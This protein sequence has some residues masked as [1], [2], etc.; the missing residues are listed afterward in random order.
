MKRPTDQATP[1][2]ASRELAE[3]PLTV[4]AQE[5]LAALEGYAASL[6]APLGEVN[7]PP[8]A[9]AAS[10]D[11]RHSD[12]I[13]SLRAFLLGANACLADPS[14]GQT[15][16]HPRTVGVEL[17]RAGQSLAAATHHAH[18]SGREALER[19]V[20]LLGRMPEQQRNGAR[21]MLLDAAIQ[22]CERLSR[23]AADEADTLV[24][25]FRWLARTARVPGYDTQPEPTAGS[26]EAIPDIETLLSDPAGA[27]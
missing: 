15:V 25:R 11:S 6:R 12:A 26:L 24:E 7:Q 4:H 10:M 13:G 14:W 8:E 18:R 1:R 21:R 17:A 2:S 19:I 16:A 27:T 3:V 5:A 22:T 9:I 23:S 20:A